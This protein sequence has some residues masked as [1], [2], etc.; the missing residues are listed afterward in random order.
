M[1]WTMSVTL[2]ERREVAL[3]QLL[4]IGRQLDSEGL[5]NGPVR[6]ARVSAMCYAV[7]YGRSQGV[8]Y[9]GGNWASFITFVN[10]A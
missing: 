2:A 3:Y 7:D 4:G 10:P 1:T 9:D 6:A 8:H 5:P